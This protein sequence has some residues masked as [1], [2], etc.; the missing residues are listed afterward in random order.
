MSGTFREWAE[1][2]KVTERHQAGLVRRMTDTIAEGLVVTDGGGL[3]IDISAG[4]SLITGY[5][6][7]F[8]A[9]SGQTLVANRI[10]H[11]QVT[12]SEQ[13]FYTPYVSA[14]TE[15]YPPN[16][17]G[18]VPGSLLIAIVQTGV[19]TISWIWNNPLVRGHITEK[20]F[21]PGEG[22][23]DK[24]VLRGIPRSLYS[25]A[26]ISPT[27]WGSLVFWPT[28]GTSRGI[29]KYVAVEINLAADEVAILIDDEYSGSESASRWYR[30]VNLFTGG[31]PSIPDDFMTTPINDHSGLFKRYTKV[32]PG[33]EEYEIFW[34]R[35]QFNERFRV[36]YYNSGGGSPTINGIAVFEELV[37]PNIWGG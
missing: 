31:W 6:Q 34:T 35:G 10:Y 3:T 26:V 27:S 20:S 28:S 23:P 11:I 13:I 9:V 37:D 5:E 4:R 36:R 24:G 32:Y 14:A 7:R 19:S 30:D 16:L 33:G 18:S 21:R 29:L 25:T 2:N 22:L 1:G 12:G 17:V 8:S 15:P